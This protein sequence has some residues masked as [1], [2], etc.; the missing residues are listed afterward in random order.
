MILATDHQ[1]LTLV[2]GT[3]VML[4]QCTTRLFVAT[5]QVRDFQAGSKVVFSGVADTKPKR[6]FA[7]KILKVRDP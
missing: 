2:D 1:Q 7:T 4:Q 5:I 6:Y 3:I